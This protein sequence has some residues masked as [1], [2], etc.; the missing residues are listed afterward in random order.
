M[1]QM[2]E[3]ELEL[4]LPMV[5]DIEIAAARAAGNLARQ[6]GMSAEKIDEMAH[7][8]IEACINAREHSSCADNRIY[9]RFVTGPGESGNTRFDVWITDHGKGFDPEAA[10]ER[11]LN[12]EG[13]AKRRGWGLQIMQAHMDEVEIQSNSGGTTIHMAKYGE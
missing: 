8:I 1:R 13:G 12:R 3:R 2:V 7:A 11:R 6:V 9:L 4:T 10:R 5:A